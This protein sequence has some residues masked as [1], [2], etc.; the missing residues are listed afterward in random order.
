MDNTP[1][2]FWLS[3][4]NVFAGFLAK[5]EEFRSINT[6]DNTVVNFFDELEIHPDDIRED[7]FLRKKDYIFCT[8]GW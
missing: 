3:Y 2:A 1:I 7:F 8:V 5:V 6:D 4:S